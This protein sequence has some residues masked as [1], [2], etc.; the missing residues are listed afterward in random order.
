MSQINRYYYRF[1]YYG[2]RQSVAGGEA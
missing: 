2:I 1:F